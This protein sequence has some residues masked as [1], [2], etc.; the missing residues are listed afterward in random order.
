MDGPFEEVLT[1]SV[2]PMDGGV[3]LVASSP[4]HEAAASSALQSK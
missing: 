2:L 4:S 3:P 1:R